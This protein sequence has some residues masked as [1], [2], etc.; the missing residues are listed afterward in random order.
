MPLIFIDTEFADLIDRDVI[1]IAL[2]TSEDTF[3]A[4]RNDFNPGRCN[5]FVRKNVLPLLRRWPDRVMSKQELTASLLEWLAKYRTQQPVI[6]FDHMY[7]WSVLTDLL[8][9]DLP[10][11]LDF[12]NILRELDLEARSN[13]FAARNVHPHH[14]LDD[15]LANQS[16][17]RA[18][19]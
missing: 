17:W 6:G 14:A 8:G 13:Y 18:T 9:D 4:E 7:D 16:A 1:S 15:A 10:A 11:W 3:Y 19:D 5:K 2:V 12:R